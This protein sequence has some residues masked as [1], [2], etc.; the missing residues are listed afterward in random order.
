MEDW[1]YEN[2]DDNCIRYML[3][4]QGNRTLVCFGINPST[5]EP[6]DLDN[7]L[8]RVQD[9]SLFNRFDSWL[10]FNVYPIRA[11]NFDDLSN[12]CDDNAHR[13]NMETITKYFENKSDI[14]VW[15]AFGD[16]IYDREYLATCWRDIYTIIRNKNISWVAT[17]INKSGSPKHPLYQKKESSL[18]EFNME[19]YLALL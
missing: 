15:V 16:L 7:T 19:D 11:T 10:M 9:I 5:A 13:K 8:E 2:D 1:L 18:L 6:N 14:D 12:T 3:G 17:G 4:T